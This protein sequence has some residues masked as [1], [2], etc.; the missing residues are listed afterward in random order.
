VKI[1]Y[2]GKDP[3]G[4]GSAGPLRGDPVKVTLTAPYEFFFI[5][6]VGITLSATATLRMEQTPTLITGAVGPTC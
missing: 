2:P 6:K 4:V 5:N 3:V 1:C